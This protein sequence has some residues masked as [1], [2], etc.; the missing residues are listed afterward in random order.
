MLHRRMPKSGDELSILGFGCMR[1][2]QKEGRIDEERAT[3]QVRLAI[4]RGVNYVDTAW[5]YHGGESEP[6]LGRA[7]AD[8]YRERVKLA[9]KLPSWLVKT[10]D[11]LDRFL[12]AQLRKLNT[13]RIDYYLLH[14]LSGTSWDKLVSLGVEDFLDRAKA[15]GKIV[16]AGFS[17]H[18]TLPEFKRIVDAYPWEFCQIQFNFLDIEHQAG[19]AGLHYA[20]AKG[21]GVVVMQ[22]LRG[23]TLGQAS[24][25]PSIGALWSEAAT[26]RTPAE[27][28]LRWV[29][30]HPEVIVAL[31]GM[32]EESQLEENLAIAAQAQANSLTEA[33]LALVA[34]VRKQYREIMKVGCT[35]CGY[36]DPCPK[37]VGIAGCFDIYNQ[38][39]MYGNPAAKFF[40]VVRLGGFISGQRG[41]ASQCEQCGDCVMKCPQNLEIPALLEKV[42]AEFEGEGLQE[43]EAMA[44][45]FLGV[46]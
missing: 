25:P 20:A 2:A 15:A 42:A 31:S 45:G 6:F 39:Y 32:N 14:S 37:G 34:R 30:N 24:P 44:K 46:A 11:D 21:L 16:N 41:Y 40:Y 22:P 19:E 26:P 3:R 27:W 29:W 23:G 17:C 36:C 1:L 4:D 12:D 18:G 33:E 10:A 8:G 43:R 5:P 9:T 28:A 35:G 7:L 38:L 13:S